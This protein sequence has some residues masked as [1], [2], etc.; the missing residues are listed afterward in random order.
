MQRVLVVDKNKN[1]LMPTSPVR[2]RQLL[3][4]GKAAVFRRYPFTII[5]QDRDSGDVQPV[6]RDTGAALR[7]AGFRHLEIE[8]FKVGGGIASPHVIGRA[9]L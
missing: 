4:K 9:T 7:A 6:T 1:P 3:S 5:L 8:D 2:A